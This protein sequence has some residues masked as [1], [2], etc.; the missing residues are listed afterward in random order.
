MTRKSAMRNGL[1]HDRRS[2]GV[3]FAGKIRLGGSL[4]HRASFST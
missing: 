1:A 4:L 2:S 3:I